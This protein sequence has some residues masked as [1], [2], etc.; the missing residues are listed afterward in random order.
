LCIGLTIALL[1]RRD[2]TRLELEKVRR[3]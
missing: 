1:A 2:S 3:G